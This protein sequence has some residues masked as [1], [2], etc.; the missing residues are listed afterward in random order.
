VGAFLLHTAADFNLHI[1]ANGLWFFFL[2]GLTVSAA[3]TRM[4][5]GHRK[6]YLPAAGTPERGRLF[7]PAAGGVL[8]ASLLFN[9]GILAAQ[10]TDPERAVLLDP[11][12]GEHRRDLAMEK[13]EQGEPA[14]A[15][16]EM[17]KAL[18]LAPPRADYLQRTGIMLSDLGRREEAD[19]FFK[20]GIRYDWMNPQRQMNYGSWLLAQGE[21]EKAL[22]VFRGAV[23][24]EPGE[25]GVYITTMVLYGMKDEE[26]REAIP[27][28]ADALYVWA[29]YLERVGRKRMAEEAY[30]EGLGLAFESGEGGWEHFQPLL[31]FYQKS[32]LTD[33]AIDLMRRAV[34]ALPG[35]AAPRT[36]LAFFLEKKME[37]A[38]AE[39][40][41]RAALE[42]DGR[43][44]NALYGLDR[45]LAK[46]Q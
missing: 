4:H 13:R 41:Y 42:I 39:E 26:V 29:A 33:R 9:G 11:L 30:L 34:A 1:P 15:L 37:Y 35:L 23:A 25:T 40:H 8:A 7:I 32:E 10:G 31:A 16:G 36:N 28:R 18:R 38:E 22:S 44:K 20:M 2:L 14:A 12:E 17:E 3:H 19:R 6:T 45:V 43:N 24:A 5:N 27:P 21:K 46:L